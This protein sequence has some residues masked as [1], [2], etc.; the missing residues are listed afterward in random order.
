MFIALALLLAL[1]WVLGFTVMK[2]S[3]VTVHLLL[4]FAMV[5]LVAHFFRRSADTPT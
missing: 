2:V 3:S 4:L 1:A 5:C